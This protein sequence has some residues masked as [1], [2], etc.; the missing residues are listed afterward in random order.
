M[1]AAGPS[2]L[3]VTWKKP[4]DNNSDI[5]GY[6]LRYRAT[7]TTL[8][9]VVPTTIAGTAITHTLTGLPP[10]DYD[11]QVVALNELRASDDVFVEADWSASGKG[12]TGAGPG[13]PTLT[14]AVDPTIPEGRE[15]IPVSVTVDVPLSARSSRSLTVTLSLVGVAAAASDPETNAE[16]PVS[17]QTPDVEWVKPLPG[18]KA[19]QREPLVF[20]FTSELSQ[21][22]MVYLKTNT[23]IDAEVEKFRIA[24]STRADTRGVFSAATT[25]RANVMVEDAEEQVYRLRLPYALES[26][27]EIKEGHPSG[28][29]TVT[30]SL[31]VL[32]ARTLPKSFVVSLKS[33][34]DASDYSLTSGGVSSGGPTAV[35]LRVDLQAGS[36]GEP[37]IILTPAPNDGD[38]VDDTITLQLLETDA[39]SPTTAGEQVGDDVMLKV[40]D[41]HRLPKVT[42]APTIMV[43]GAAVTSLKEGETGTVT[44]MA[45]RGTAADATPDGETIKVALTHGAA[46]SASAADYSL[47]SDMVTIK[48][49]ETSG[50]FMLE[51]LADDEID[52]DEL[53]LMA[54]VTGEDMYGEAADM[55]T[56]G[57]ISFTEGTTKLVYP[58]MEEELQAVIYPARDAGMGDDMMFNPGETI[59]IASPGSMFNTAEGVTLSFTA[60]SDMEDV[61]TVGVTGSGMV[62]VTA[63]DMAGVDGAHHH[64][65]SRELGGGGGEGSPADRSERGQHHLPG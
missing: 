27:G 15:S 20:N 51:V 46:S 35:S 11:V 43:D 16:L 57:P 45:D 31:D 60:E 13:K 42:M 2:S 29:G 33:A 38:R 52:A 26:S 40:V 4:A 9:S 49:K 5:T 55:V 62:T 28:G 22:Q 24:A 21:T 48:G 6:R 39:D 18:T 19:N 61:A 37:A 58:K 8:W 34:Q 23:D 1:I 47:S 17:S 64:H 14:L 41:Q 54:A 53:V 44:L 3:K 50:T 63:Q 59:E 7:G 65:R 30:V 12:K 25:V 36:E 56:L 10:G 32:P